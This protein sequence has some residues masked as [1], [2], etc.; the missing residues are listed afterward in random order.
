MEKVSCSADKLTIALREGATINV[1]GSA[2]TAF[3]HNRN[4][5]KTASSVLK[6]APT[7]TVAG[8]QIAQAYI[9]GGTG[10]GGSRSGSDTKADNEWVLKQ[11][12]VYTI[13]FTNDSSGD[14]VVNV[15]NVWYEETST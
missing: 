1:D 15:N 13:T 9:G 4:S 8:T 7:V 11:N 5:S 10:V 6:N 14:N 2:I 12:T 3:N